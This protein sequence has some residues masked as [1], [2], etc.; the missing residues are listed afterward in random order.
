M[1]YA[2]ALLL[3]L[4]CHSEAEEE[5]DCEWVVVIAEPPIVPENKQ[6]DVFA[7]E[8]GLLPL[9]LSGVPLLDTTT[10]DASVDQVVYRFAIDIDWLYQ[11]TENAV[12]FNEF[13]P[14]PGSEVWVEY[15]TEET[16]SAY[17]EELGAF[18]GSRR[19]FCL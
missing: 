14:T 11:P 10:V 15:H 7:I 18:G 12:V 9:Y 3:L 4:G 6:L 13:V 16:L 17:E 1:R 2:I 5:E 19:S 8:D